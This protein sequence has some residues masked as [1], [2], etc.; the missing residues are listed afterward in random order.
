MKITAFSVL[1]VLALAAASI[2]SCTKTY[3]VTKG[4]SGTSPLSDN[5]QRDC[6]LTAHLYPVPPGA[7]RMIHARWTQNAALVKED[8]TV[9]GGGLFVPRGLCSQRFS[10]RGFSRSK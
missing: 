2:S 8:S 5:G 3:Y 7:Y 4:V 9:A 10:G 1:L 6:S